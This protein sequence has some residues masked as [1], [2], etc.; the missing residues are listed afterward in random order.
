MKTNS[1]RRVFSGGVVIAGIFWLFD[2]S[3]D[4]FWFKEGSFVESLMGLDRMEFW[5]RF[6]IVALII[7]FS[8]YASKLI[9]ERERMVRGHQKDIEELTEALAQV[10]TLEGLI[11]ICAHCKNIRDDEGLW[12]RIEHYIIERSNADFTHG[13]CPDCTVNMM[14]EAKDIFE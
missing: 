7:G 14:K 4:A 9:S 1:K 13:I 3:L 5:M 12:K 8:Y 6:M 11:P 2:A 10:K